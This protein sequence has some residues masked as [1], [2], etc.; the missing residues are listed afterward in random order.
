VLVR[1][2]QPLDLLV[3]LLSCMEIGAVPV[4]VNPTLVSN[5]LEY[6]ALLSRPDAAM[7]GEGLEVDVP[8]LDGMGLWVTSNS[9]VHRRRR[10][11]IEKAPRPPRPT[12]AAAILFTSG[13]TAKPKG[14][15]LRHESYYAMGTDLSALLGIEP[16]RDAVLLHHPL[17]HVAGQ[18]CSALPAIAGR[19]PLI[20]PDRF[21]AGKFWDEAERWSPTIWM[22]GLAFLEMVSRRGG[23][24]PATH[25]FRHVVSNLR[26]DTW[27]LATG[28][29]NLPM[30]TYFGQTENCGRGSLALEMQTYE[31]GYVGGLY[32]PRDG[33]RIVAGEGLASAGEVGEIEFRGPGVMTGYYGDEAASHDI[34]RA[35]GWLRTGD[36]G[37]LDDKGSLF[38][39]GRIKNLI[40]RAGENIAAEEVELVLLRHPAVIDVAVL[41]IQDPVREEE[42]KVVLVLKSGMDVD[43]ADL[44]SH[45]A[46]QLADYKV[47]RYVDIAQ[48]LPRTPSGK[49]DIAAVRRMYSSVETSWDRESLANATPLKRRRGRISS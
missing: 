38:F 20:M 16:N 49:T 47:P 43:L 33:M 6:I 15:V 37:W 23:S 27:A 10:C 8:T 18:A 2:E 9:V 21:S 17:F 40:K 39:S 4:P 19:C 24:P 3:S 13:S 44:V 35:E 34:L 12:D 26:P 30:G 25:S 22:T 11:A 42:V 45:C 1:V 46:A 7:T 36:L 14:V 48:E 5:E 31:S 32:G 28:R 29:L 41:G